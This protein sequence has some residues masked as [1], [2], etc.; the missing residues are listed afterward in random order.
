MG[1][2]TTAEGTAMVRNPQGMHARPAEMFVRLASK[3]ESS[4]EL[5]KGAECADGKSILSILTLFAE[6]GTELRIQAAG[7]DAAA[8]VEQ[9][10]KLVE[11]GFQASSQTKDWPAVFFMS[12]SMVQ[13][14]LR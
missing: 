11:S 6:Q 13:Y 8:A 4:V 7:P 10:V 5:F 1:N 9:L 12:A 14:S 2:T 3:F